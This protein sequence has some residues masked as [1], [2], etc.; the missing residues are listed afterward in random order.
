MPIEIFIPNIRAESPNGGRAWYER[1]PLRKQAREGAYAATRDALRVAGYALGQLHRSG[2]CNGYISFVNARGEAYPVRR[3]ILTRIAPSD[4]LDR[5]NLAF[6]L[7]GVQDGVARALGVND[8]DAREKVRPGPVLWDSSQERGP[9]GV[10]VTI[11][12]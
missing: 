10:R 6:A 12:P 8:R 5:D 7:K 11:E 3:V 4:G 2:P 9:W 1:Q